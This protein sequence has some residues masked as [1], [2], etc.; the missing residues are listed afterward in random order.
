MQI[1]NELEYKLMLTKKQF[2]NITLTYHANH[3]YTQ[4]NYYFTHPYLQK[5]HY[6]LRVRHKENTYEM[7]LKTP[8]QNY[9]KEYNLMIS[10]D[11][12]NKLK[13]HQPLDNEIIQILKPHLDPTTLNQQ[14][15]LTTHRYDYILEHG[16]L[17]LDHNTYCNQEDY[18]LEFEVNDPIKGY[19]Q[20]KDIL[21]TFQL[22][23]QKNNDSKIV[24][25]LKAYKNL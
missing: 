21:Q 22:T 6:M 14:F 11:D 18:E 16:I 4:T 8:H 13:N 19:K 10:L 17:S 15:S 9:Q 23:Y 12:F 3:D 25:A 20:F 1:N 5:H 24:R 2:Q 7:T